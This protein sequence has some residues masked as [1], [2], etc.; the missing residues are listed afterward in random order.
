MVIIVVNN[1]K[2]SFGIIISIIIISFG[3]FL[4]SFSYDIAT[5]PLTLYTVYLDGKNIGNI[6]SKDSFESYVNGKEEE[7][8]NKYNVDTVFTPKGV[9]IKKNFT[10][11]NDISSD[12]EVYNKIISNKNF[13]VKGYEIKVTNRDDK[14]DN[15]VLYVL[16]K[17]TFDE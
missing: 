4:I 13:T 10:Y 6:L 1:S 8:K 2:W 12:E 17:E 14:D 15:T 16:S 11:S 3:I 9:E 5:E 7:L